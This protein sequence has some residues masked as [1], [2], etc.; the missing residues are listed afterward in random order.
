MLDSNPALGDSKKHSEPSCYNINSNDNNL[1]MTFNS[2]R[3]ANGLYMHVFISKQ[4]FEPGIISSPF[5]DV[6]TEAPK[7]K[8]FDLGHSRPIIFPLF[9]ELLRRNAVCSL[10]HP[11]PRHSVRGPHLEVRFPL[12]SQT[13]HSLSPLHS[14]TQS[15]AGPLGPGPEA[16]GWRLEASL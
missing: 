11:S 2:T 16:L 12:T 5:T 10:P 15:T 6:E 8:S 4:P 7:G 1:S 3:C 14:H 9:P 13:L